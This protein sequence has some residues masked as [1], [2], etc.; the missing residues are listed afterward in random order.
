[1]FTPTRHRFA[2]A[3]TRFTGAVLCVVFGSLGAQAQ[4]PLEPVTLQL[5]WKHAFQFAGYYAAIEQG[6]YADAGFDVTLQE[7]TDERS[8]VDFLLAGEADYAI[9]GSEIVIHRANGAPLVALATIFQH[10]PYGFLVREDSGIESVEDFVGKRVMLNG[11]IQDAELLSALRNAGLAEDDY[12]RQLTSFDAMSLVRGET[13]V[14][15]AY[16]TDQLFTLEEQGIDGRYILPQLYGVDFYSDILVT[17]EAHV[18]AGPERVQAFRDASLKGWNYALNH[19]DELIDLI[20]TQYNT[21]EFSRAHL[22]YEAHSSREMILPLIVRLGYMNPERWEHIRDVFVTEGVLPAESRIDGLLYDENPE[23]LRLGQWLAQHRLLLLGGVSLLVLMLLSA[24]ILH[25]RRLV[26]QRTTELAENQRKARQQHLQLQKLLDTINGISW[27]F[28]L[29]QGRFTFVSPNLKRLLGY[30]HAEMSSL[31]DWLN[32]I[33]DDDR[34]DARMCCL[35]E[36]QAGRDHVFEYRMRKRNGEIISVLDVVRVLKGSNGTPVK[37]AGFIVDISERK[38]AERALRRAQKMDAV[39][40]LTGGIAHDFNNILGIIQGNV[41]LMEQQLDDPALLQESIDSLQETTQRAIKLTQQLLGFSRARS[42]HAEAAD[43]NQVIDQMRELTASSLTPEIKVRYELGDALWFCNIDSGDF[44]NAL[45]NLVLNARDAMPRGGD[46]VIRTDNICI[47]RATTV[48]TGTL[49]PGDYV[50]LLVTDSGVGIP[51]DQLERIFEP[52]YTTKD[53]GQGSGLGLPMVFGFVQRAG[54]QIDVDTHVGSG[55]SFTLYLQRT[56]AEPQPREETV[57]QLQPGGAERERVL[58]VDDEPALLS[59]TARR[60]AR[61]GYDVLTARDA[62]SA[63]DVLEREPD[64]DLL[65]TD[66]VM[67][68]GMNGYEL[69]D[70]ALSRRPQLKVLLTTGFTPERTGEDTGTRIR[71]QVLHKPYGQQVLLDRIREVL[72]SA[73]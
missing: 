4:T 32:M 44:Q 9:T 40:Q 36:T 52:F 51:A 73:A 47:A 37:P 55:T 15:N 28:D 71:R 50:L 68:G 56:T 45:L 26:T 63:L 8:P 42:E 33:V 29:A 72:D 21:Q 35:T 62:Q 13:D 1:M 17:T 65:F 20:L 3:V 18:A 24:A 41:D 64:I 48:K 5:K 14:F 60:L 16:V 2:A 27:E 66:V 31:D 43:I 46:L 6:Y 57:V 58:V 11:G 7:L 38:Q 30:S 70:S 59:L 54:G 69:V 39:G 22:E 53:V 23:D 61:Q 34:E 12:E 19:M 25:T 67:P 49:K 10:S